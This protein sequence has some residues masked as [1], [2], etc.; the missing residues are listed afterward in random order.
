MWRYEIKCEWEIF[1]EHSAVSKLALFFRIGYRGEQ[2]SIL[3][4]NISKKR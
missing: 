4:V 1:S 3:S 2:F